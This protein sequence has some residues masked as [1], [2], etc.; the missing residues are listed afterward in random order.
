[1]QTNVIRLVYSIDD[2]LIVFFVGHKI[3]TVGVEQQDP[4]VA[5]LLMQKIEVSLLDVFQIS[6]AD[7]LL[8]T[9]PTLTDV[10]LQSLHIRIKIH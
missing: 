5:L 10:G 4:H 7:L 9:A 3:K 8:I 6:I 1:M 2:T